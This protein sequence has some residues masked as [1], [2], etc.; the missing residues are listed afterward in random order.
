MKKYLDI[1]RIVILMNKRYLFIF[2]SSFTL[3]SFQS[4]NFAL[5]NKAFYQYKKKHFPALKNCKTQACRLQNAFNTGNKKGLN[6]RVKESYK[7]LHL[8]HL[9]TP[10]G[11]H[12]FPLFIIVK[13]LF[14]RSFLNF[15]LLSLGFFL[16]RFDQFH[17]LERII[18]MKVIFSLIQSLNLNF[19]VFSI[20]LFSMF[21]SL[22]NSNYSSS[23]LSFAY[24]YLFIGSIVSARNRL[25]TF[26]FIFFS[27]ILIAYFNFEAVSLIAPII[28][29][30]LTI[31]F[32]FL[33]PFIFLN[34]W[35]NTYLFSADFS[36][37]TFL[38]HKIVNVSSEIISFFQ[39]IN[40]D[41]MI[42]LILCF[43]L[44]SK[45]SITILWL[46]LYSINLNIFLVNNLSK[47]FY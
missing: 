13:K 1:A 8:L 2:I 44:S 14:S 22:V 9:F 46:S 21:L 24:S 6:K 37:P 5:S 15:V 28:G 19:S 23:P 16:W 26:V 17:S 43:F 3:F 25:E 42:I 7:K 34:F 47:T 30:L 33:F 12:I 40:I 36:Y 45:R 35:I 11:I 20:F 41:F 29:S 18:T 38:F 39:A 10:S 31:L 27:N 4:K 32:S